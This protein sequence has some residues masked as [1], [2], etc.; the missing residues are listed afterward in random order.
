MQ[1][2]MHGKAQDLVLR[3]AHY[4]MQSENGMHLIHIPLL[5]FA[6]GTSLSIELENVKTY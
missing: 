3:A 1:T 2:G 6:P 4:L 5:L